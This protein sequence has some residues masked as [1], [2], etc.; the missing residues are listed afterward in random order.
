[1][2]IFVEIPGVK[3]CSCKAQNKYLPN[4]SA[5]AL[6]IPLARK[7]ARAAQ[8]LSS[9]EIPSDLSLHQIDMQLDGRFRFRPN[10]F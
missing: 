4:L 3:E 2:N 6:S 10:R 8:I 7:N 9:L 5:N 1:M